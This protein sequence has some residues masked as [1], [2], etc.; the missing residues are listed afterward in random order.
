MFSDLQEEEIMKKDIETWRS[1]K[2]NFAD[3][4]V[5]LT[6]KEINMLGDRHK[7]VVEVFSKYNFERILDIGCGDGN[8][9]ILLKKICGA[10]EVYGI[11]ISEKGVQMAKK[12]GVKAFK[13]DVD[14]EDFPFEDNYFDAIYAGGIIEHLFDPDHFLD[15]VYRVLKPNG[16]F[17]LDTPNLA[18]LYNRVALLLGYLPF[19]MQV[20]LKYSLGHLYESMYQAREN[21][22]VRASDHIRF[23]TLKSLVMLLKKHDFSILKIYGSSDLTSINKTPSL[24]A[25]KIYR[26]YLSKDPIFI[27]CHNSSL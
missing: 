14:R 2:S 10:K 3:S 24:V 21:G 5:G 12:N 18:S 16:I 20:S 17:I 13:L 1:K 8:F 4:F 19:D 15:E 9:S 6:S 7:R 11:E 23:F 22:Y 27:S 25:S 26:C